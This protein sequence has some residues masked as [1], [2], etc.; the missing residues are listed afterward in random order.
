ML[1]IVLSILA[2]SASFATG[3]L[4]QSRAIQSQAICTSDFVWMENAEQNSPCET[5]AQI[6]AICNGGNWIVPALA[7]NES[8]VYDIPDPA[9][10][11]ATFCT[12]SWA[13]YNLISACT[14]C[15][16]GNLA[17][18]IVEWTDYS[19]NC[20]GKL[21]NTY[22]PSNITIPSDVTIPFWAGENPTT[23]TNGLFSVPAAQQIANQGHPDLVG[24]VPTTHKKSSNIG[25]IVG[26]VI[27]GLVV[28]AAAAAIAFYILRR[29][30]KPA[31]SGTA[32]SIIEK[33]NHMRSISDLTTN[34]ALQG[35]TTLSS[36]PMNPPTSPTI[37][38]HN[39][40]VRSVP[41]FSS[42]V[43]STL[44]YGSASPPPGRQAASPPPR[45]REDVIEPFT[46][47]PANA[48]VSDRKQ[49]NGAY[50]VYDSPTAPPPTAMRMEI[51]RPV[52]P[53]QRTRFNPPAYTESSP[54]HSGT[55]SPPPSR[56]IH[57]GKQGSTDTLQSLT[58]SR[59]HGQR[60]TPAHSPNSSGSGMNNIMGITNP[61]IP[62]NQAGGSAVPQ[63]HGRQ[64][65]ASRD[66]KRRPTEES[67][68][69]RDI[70]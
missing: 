29:Q 52:T 51:T 13:S 27:G 43:E 24:T 2:G 6:N 9:K 59:S 55:T 65:S 41:Y 22:F 34:S 28:I 49:T 46:L 54:S 44:P 60:P 62:N 33:P 19:S 10:G 42:A 56:P 23:W 17:T 4:L 66:E 25:A 8:N 14:A 1:P 64:V 38:T 39:T 50:P 21:S 26:G 57:R 40:S 61:A 45:N 53:T 16:G 70:A 69:A 31:S 67:F 63:G 30:R 20:A 5:A 58:S 48:N 35:Y 37:L 7:Q 18:E 68:S 11:T 15:Q 32:S 3:A 47:P 12:C 36:T